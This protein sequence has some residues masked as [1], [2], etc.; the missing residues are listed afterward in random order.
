MSRIKRPKKLAPQD[1]S[2]VSHIFSNCLIFNMNNE[3]AHLFLL[4]SLCDKEDEPKSR[5]DL[6]FV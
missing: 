3:P 1:Y 5:T 2:Q 6:I 4:E